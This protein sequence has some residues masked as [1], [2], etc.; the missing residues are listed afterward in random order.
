[1]LCVFAPPPPLVAGSHPCPLPPVKSVGKAQ[2]KQPWA[3]CAHQKNEDWIAGLESD[4]DLYLDEGKDNGQAAACSCKRKAM[5]C[6]LNAHGG[7]S[8]R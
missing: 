4:S 1:M 8:F 6:P 7:D 5:L 2:L 3:G